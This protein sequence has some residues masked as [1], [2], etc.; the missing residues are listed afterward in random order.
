VDDVVELH[1]DGADGMA[2]GALLLDDHDDPVRQFRTTGD[3]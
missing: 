1:E 2:G 3:L